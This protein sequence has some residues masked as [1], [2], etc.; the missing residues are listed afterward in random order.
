MVTFIKLNFREKCNV[1][2]NPISEMKLSVHL[3][4]RFA[5]CC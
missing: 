1:N 5:L 2:Q 3:K 4:T